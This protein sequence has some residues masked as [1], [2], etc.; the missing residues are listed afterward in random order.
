MNEITIMRLKSAQNQLTDLADD[1]ENLLIVLRA[2]ETDDPK[3]QA[4]QTALDIA[5]TGNTET[6]FELAYRVTILL[7]EIE[8]GDNYHG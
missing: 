6:A 3:S 5:L 7:D 2:I 8:C 4:I 1:L